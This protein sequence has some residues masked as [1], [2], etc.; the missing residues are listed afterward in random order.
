[1]AL[2]MAQTLTVE[3]VLIFDNQEIT[4]EWPD[5]FTDVDTIPG[6][7]AGVSPGARKCTIT[8]SNAL[9]R[10]G[11]DFNFEDAYQNATEL[12]CVV[13]QIGASKKV[14]GKFLVREISRGSGV[15]QPSIQ[16]LRLQSVGEVPRLE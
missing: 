2:F 9:R 12:E 1:M 7:A 8:I 16:R 5:H 15:G 11:A 10:E 3:G 13:Q 6:G 4:V 14:K